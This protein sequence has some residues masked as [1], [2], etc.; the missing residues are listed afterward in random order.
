MPGVTI[1]GHDLFAVYEAAGEAIRR[2]REGG[3]PSLIECKVNRYYGH[4]EGDAQTYRG[5]N[6]V[7]EIRNEK[8][9]L[10]L[11]R[12]R[13]TSADLV[14]EDDLDRIDEEVERLIDESVDEAKAAANPSQDRLLADVYVS[15]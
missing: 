14:D 5:E 12:Q 11:F 6:E 1:D 15:Y 2:A 4:F 8:D 3:G 9:C 7:E 10:T 13:V